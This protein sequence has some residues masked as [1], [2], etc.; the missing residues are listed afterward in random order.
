MLRRR[1]TYW[2]GALSQ[3]PSRVEKRSSD[4]SPAAQ[5]IPAWCWQYQ[6]RLEAAAGQICPIQEG[7]E[8]EED[9]LGLGEVEMQEQDP[10]QTK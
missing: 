4:K 9:T 5:E 1:P 8:P 10:V 2:S 3:K 6:Q 7:E